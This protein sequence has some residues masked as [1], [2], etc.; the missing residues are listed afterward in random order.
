[1]GVP[2]SE[3]SEAAVIL[4]AAM[5]CLGFLGASPCSELILWQCD[6]VELHHAM[7]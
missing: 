6:N 7:S 3:H 5:P 2:C 4:V 1:M